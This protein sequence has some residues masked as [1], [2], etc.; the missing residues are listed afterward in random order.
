MRYKIIVLVILLISLSIII[1]GC[2]EKGTTASSEKIPTT[3]ED[4]KQKDLLSS[5]VTGNVM[6]VNK[7]WDADAENDGIVI[8][9]DLK[10]SSGETVKF[11]NVKIPVQIE[12]YTTK[13]EDY[14]DVKDRLVYSGNAYIDSWK[15]GNMF[16][17]G[18]IK[19]PY[20]EIKTIESDKEFG[21]IYVKMTLPDGRIIEA[22]S[23]FGDRI[24]PEK[25]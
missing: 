16:F 6:T 8:F 5:I 2:T 10:D 9:P 23:D 4:N 7:N 12:I 18:G 14:K 19:V 11:E 20:E 13:T 24:K 22:K 17:N 15:D 21:I 3:S 1:S 25:N